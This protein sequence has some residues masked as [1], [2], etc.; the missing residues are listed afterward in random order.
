MS[1]SAGANIDQIYL[2]GGAA[3]TPG[4]I[5][6]IEEQTGVPTSILDP[7]KEIEVPERSFKEEYLVDSAP[8]YATAIGL[9][10]RSASQLVRNVPLIAVSVLPQKTSRRIEQV[11]NEFNKFAICS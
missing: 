11:Q 4:L 8:Q 7:F 9:A 10:M 3:Q 1:N 6:A 5:A 2:A